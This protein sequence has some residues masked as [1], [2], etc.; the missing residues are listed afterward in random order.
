MG[1]GSEGACFSH[2]HRDLFD[3]ARAFVALELV[4]DEPARVLGCRAQPGALRQVVDFD[5]EPID[6]EFELVDLFHQL[7][8]VGQRLVQAGQDLES[9]SDRDAHLQHVCQEFVM[10]LEAIRFDESCGAYAKNRIR[11]A[12]CTVSGRADLSAPRG[13]ISRIGKRLFTCGDLCSP[14]MGKIGVIDERF[15]TDFENRGMPFSLQFERHAD[16]R[17]GVVRDVVSL[18]NCR[19]RG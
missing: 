19:R 2:L 1:H 9:G 5:D 10:G 17:A 15:A 14:D 11:L 13:R 7:L 12:G 8:A 16:Q 6:F 18:Q 4:G 3:A